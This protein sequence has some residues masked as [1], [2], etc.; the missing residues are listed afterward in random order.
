MQNNWI[1][2]YRISLRNPSFKKGVRPQKKRC[3]MWHVH[4]PQLHVAIHRLCEQDGRFSRENASWLTERGRLHSDTTIPSKTFQAT[5]WRLPAFSFSVHKRNNHWTQRTNLVSRVAY[6]KPLSFFDRFNQLEINSIWK[7][8][9]EQILCLFC[10]VLSTL[11]ELWSSVPGSFIKNF[12]GYFHW[13][14]SVLNYVLS[15]IFVTDWK[16]IW[17]R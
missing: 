16:L 1:R 3:R 5:A 7:V 8:F 14:E 17:I 4:A 2:F 13:T 12:R 10:V 15:G 9:K 6:S 11:C